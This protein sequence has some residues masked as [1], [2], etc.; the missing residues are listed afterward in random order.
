MQPLNDAI[1]AAIFI[2]IPKGIICI[3]TGRK[4]KKRI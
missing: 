3:R 2:K 1:K 4:K